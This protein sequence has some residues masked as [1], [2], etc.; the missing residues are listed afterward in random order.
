MAL[1]EAKAELE[2]RES[3]DNALRTGPLSRTM[4]QCLWQYIFLNIFELA[5]RPSDS[6]GGQ[7]QPPDRA[8]RRARLRHR[9]G[10]LEHD[11]AAGLP[12][13]HPPRRS[14]RQRLQHR[15][16]R[17]LSGLRRRSVLMDGEEA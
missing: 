13:R 15:R 12:G 17:L 16:R 9:H 10:R 3:L 11:A 4:F 8:K 6:A 14:L 5:V 1:P 7:H 2:I